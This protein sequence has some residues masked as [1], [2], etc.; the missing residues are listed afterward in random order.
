MSAAG[1][2]AGS[3]ETLH[4]RAVTVIAAATCVSGFALMVLP[5]FA[6]SALPGVALL[7]RFLGMDVPPRY[8][9][10]LIGLG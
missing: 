7:P 1:P 5:L 9:P 10:I 2:S 3:L 6:S 8:E 4:R